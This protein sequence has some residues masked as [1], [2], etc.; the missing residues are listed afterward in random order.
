MSDPIQSDHSFTAGELQANVNAAEQLF[1]STDKSIV[2]TVIAGRGP[3]EGENKI[4]PIIAVAPP[5]ENGI[6]VRTFPLVTDQHEVASQLD[7]IEQNEP[8]ILR[9][10]ARA[11]V[12]GT[13]AWVALFDK[14]PAVAPPPA[15]VIRIE[16]KI[17]HFGGPDDTG[18]ARF[19]DTAFVFDDASAAD[20]PGFFLPQTP[21]FPTGW[22]RRLDTT[23]H[24]I[25]CRWD[26]LGVPK[27]FLR[28]PTSLIT[29]LN[30]RTGVKVTDVRAIDAGPAAWTG[31]VADLSNSVEELLGLKTDDIAAV[32]IP[33]PTGSVAE[34]KL[35]PEDLP[36][37]KAAPG[38]R[39]TVF[40]DGSYTRR[41]ELAGQFGCT[42]T[43][44]F[45]FNSADGP[46]FGPEVYFKPGDKTAQ[47]FAQALLDAIRSL[48]LKD[49]RAD[50]LQAATAG[51][52]AGYI[53]GY[54]AHAVLLEPLFI[55]E[56]GQAKWIKD[57]A[58]LEVLSQVVAMAIRGET[59]ESDLIGL[60]IGHLGNTARPGDT[61]APA[62][63]G[64]VETDF[65]APMARR[66]AE[67][68][69]A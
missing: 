53:G 46:A 32:L 63:G 60:S 22:G 49:T 50:G 55:S 40:L 35:K 48:H 62:F 47:T 6:V 27:N 58:N 24:Y 56:A 65:N 19:E 33:R 43:I 54:P 41:K 18:M 69:S 39:R 51:S 61:G 21:G 3:D 59:D 26:Q 52:R 38:Q 5:V 42:H 37:K 15:N 25:A 44:D 23:K 1:F 67:I 30:A 68:F 13:L 45:H 57:S 36:V 12:D 31:R 20:Y 11:F 4:V 29:V 14:K 28:K 7:A 2:Y 17:S 64:G 10:W 66:I 8:L 34:T 9:R 16:G